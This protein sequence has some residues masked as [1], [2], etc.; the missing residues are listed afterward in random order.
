M[1]NLVKK[2]TFYIAFYIYI[3]SKGFVDESTKRFKTRPLRYQHS[4]VLN[5]IARKTDSWLSSLIPGHQVPEW[6]KV[7][8]HMTKY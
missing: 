5:S 1:M 7:E 3:Y 6:M 4:S 2:K 8:T